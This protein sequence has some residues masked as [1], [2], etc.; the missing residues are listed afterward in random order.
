MT[1]NSAN[2]KYTIVGF[3]V[4]VSLAAI[5]LGIIWISSG[6][7]FK[8]YKTYLVY[9]KE[10]VTGLNKDSTVEY[11]GVEVG[12][13]KNIELSL[14]NPQIVKLLLSIR[15]NTPITQGTVAMLGSRGITG[16]TYIALKDNSDDLRPLETAPGQSYPVIKTAPSIFLRLDAALNLLTNNFRQINES[17]QLLLNKDNL[18]S[19]KSTLLNL[20][21]VTDV[22]AQNSMRINTI[23]VNTATASQQFTPLLQSS[24]GTMKMLEIQTLPQTYRLLANMDEVTRELAEIALEIRQNPSMLIRGVERNNLGPGETR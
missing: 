19:I 15:S 9:M 6:S 24:A 21:Q 22:L 2:K 8:S 13:V 17:I 10:S 1:D 4:L 12:K 16:I 3:S 5:V 7:T 20:N 23:I 18:R 11:N 14:K